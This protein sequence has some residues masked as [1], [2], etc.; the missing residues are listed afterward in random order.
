MS[1]VA[2]QLK[3]GAPIFLPNVQLGTFGAITQL[4]SMARNRTDLLDVSAAG[5]LAGALVSA[6]LFGAGLVYS[7]GGSTVSFDSQF[8]DPNAHNTC[9]GD[10]ALRRSKRCN[11]SRAFTLIRCVCLLWEL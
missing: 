7:A 10:D 2:L 5:P 9:P 1:P 8:S 3:L 4:R 11:F 6:V